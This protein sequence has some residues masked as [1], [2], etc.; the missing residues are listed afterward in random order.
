MRHSNMLL[1]LGGALA[2]SASL[3]LPAMAAW[4]PTRPITLIVGFPAGGGSDIT[5]RTVAAVAEKTCKTPIIV[6][7]RPG[8]SGT[9]AA[10]FVKN[11]T[12]DGYTLL[13]A[14]GSE[15]T[16]VGNYQKIDYDPRT[17][18]TPIMQIVRLR[19][20]LGTRADAPWKTLQEFIAYA[21]AHPG[22]L[23]Y[24]SSGPGSLYHSA[25]LVL[26]KEAGIKL[27][28]VPYKGAAPS[29]AA[30]VGG[31]VDVTAFGPDDGKAMLDAGE[32]RALTVFSPTRYPGYPDVPTAMELGYNVYVENM[33]GLVGPAGMAPDV[34]AYLGKCFKEA[35]ESK[36]FIDQAAKRNME[37]EYLP[38]D[39]FQEKVSNMYNIIGE[40][41]RADS[42]H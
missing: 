20:L 3:A 15:S 18:F 5:A 4:A 23:K 9:I 25:M 6:E 24:G 28:H 33:K 32:L 16:S 19:N 38:P 26:S 27:R 7:N 37:I 13:V 12:P 39:K 1:S 36:E 2:L 29:I 11:A 22:E 10:T 17:D 42:Q 21:K 34:V 14:G 31:H 30:L 41:L 35:I 40:A 8:A